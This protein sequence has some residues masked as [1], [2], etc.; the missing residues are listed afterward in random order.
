MLEIHSVALEFSKALRSRFQLV[1]KSLA[2][3]QA[4]E[5]NPITKVLLSMYWVAADCCGIVQVRLHTRHQ[6]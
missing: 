3:N 6:L 2:C 5:V 1:L 4:E